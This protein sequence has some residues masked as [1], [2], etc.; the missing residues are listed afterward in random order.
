MHLATILMMLVCVCKVT[1]GAC[2]PRVCASAHVKI[3]TT[4]KPSQVCAYHITNSEYTNTYPSKPI[5]YPTAPGPITHPSTNDTTV[6]PA[7]Q[8]TKPVQADAY[9]WYR[10]LGIAMF[11]NAFVG[12]LPAF[13]KVWKWIKK[14]SVVVCASGEVAGMMVWALERL[15]AR[16]PAQS[17]QEIVKR[18]GTKSEGCKEVGV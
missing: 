18:L 4:I 3:T 16:I 9:V 5:T 6:T 8:Q 14:Q 13:A 2:I 11:V 15:Q 10:R 7:Q 1:R 12:N 17:S